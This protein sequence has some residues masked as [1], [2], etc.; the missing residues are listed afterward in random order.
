[1]ESF[2]RPSTLIVHFPN[3]G[4][5]RTAGQRVGSGNFYADCYGST[6]VHTCARQ[7]KRLKTAHTL[8]D[9]TAVHTHNA[10][11]QSNQQEKEAKQKVLRAFADQ[12][13]RIIVIV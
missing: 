12:F 2:E 4:S 8:Y 9:R 7:K 1:M 3:F 10:A 6:T 13:W 5:F 11:T